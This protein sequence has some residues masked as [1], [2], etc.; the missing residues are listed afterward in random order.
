M[1]RHLRTTSLLL[2]IGCTCAIPAHA[3]ANPSG[4]NLT[5]NAC[6]GDGGQANRAFA[7]NTN[8]GT[9]NL[10]SSVVVDQ[11]VSDIEGIELTLLVVAE[12]SMLPAWWTFFNAGACR[13]SALVFSNVGNGASVACQDWGGAFDGVAA[14]AG[15]DLGFAGANTARLRTAVSV[16]NP[17]GA[18]QAGIEYYT[19]TFKLGHQQTFGLGSCAGCTVPVCIG[20]SSA[21]I[22]TLDPAN[23][24][25]L[26]TPANTPSS[27][28][29]GWQGGAIVLTPLACSPV[30][31]PTRHTVWGQV[32]SLYR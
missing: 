28:W 16:S 12:T 23:D 17:L 9:E 32:K 5:W 13:R 22:V 3:A 30:V 29:V 1:L 4:V 20:Y 2:A 24:R 10:F 15:Y 21:R 14:I 31:T 18:M 25:L 27:Q 19:G 11:P 26:T 7:C 8:F 6:F